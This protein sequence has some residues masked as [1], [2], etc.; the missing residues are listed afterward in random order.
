MNYINSHCR[1]CTLKTAYGEWQGKLKN[2]CLERKKIYAI[3]T[4]QWRADHYR[5]TVNYTLYIVCIYIHNTLY[6]ADVWF[7]ISA[8]HL[9]TIQDI[10]F[11][12]I[13]LQR[14]TPAGQWCGAPNPAQTFHAEFKGKK[15][16]SSGGAR[17]FKRN[18]KY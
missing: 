14:H 2:V 9:I 18:G 15:Q 6:T 10:K 12:L 11:T 16:K 3:G 17:P 1:G 8:S 5:Q 13:W 7:A 4:V